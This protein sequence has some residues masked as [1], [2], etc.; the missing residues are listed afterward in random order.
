MCHNGFTLSS[1]VYMLRYNLYLQ[2][3][4]ISIVYIGPFVKFFFSV[5]LGLSLSRLQVRFNRFSCGRRP[6]HA[7][8]AVTCEI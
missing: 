5:F 1:C 3:P 8:Q 4:T 6:K 7:K 2:L